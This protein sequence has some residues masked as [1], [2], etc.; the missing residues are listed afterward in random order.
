MSSKPSDTLRG[1]HLTCDTE[2]FLSLASSA[3]L[4]SKDPVKA[5]S[6]DPP[7]VAIYLDK[8]LTWEQH[9]FLVNELSNQDRKIRYALECTVDF[10]SADVDN[11]IIQ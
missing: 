7:L 5:L 4:E 2:T 3:I 10:P 11:R 1:R 9:E 8:M 6:D